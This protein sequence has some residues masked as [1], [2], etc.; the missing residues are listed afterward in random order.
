MRLDLSNTFHNNISTSSHFH[1]SKWNGIVEE[2]YNKNVDD[3]NFISLLMPQAMHS[4]TIS[5]M[6]CDVFVFIDLI[7]LYSFILFIL[8]VRHCKLEEIGIQRPLKGNIAAGGF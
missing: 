6:N 3:F 5:F 4:V 1:Q 8:I 2:K 7:L